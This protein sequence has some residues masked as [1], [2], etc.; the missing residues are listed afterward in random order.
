MSKKVKFP[1][2]L[3]A[4]DLLEGHVLYWQNDGW[5]REY[6]N[7]IIANNEKEGAVLE[8]VAAQETAINKVVDAELVE[9]SLENQTI[10]P[11]HFRVKIKVSG[12]TIEYGL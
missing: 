4:H 10:I 6:I 8:K 12:P 11:T 7:S 3:M 5:S 9:I 1:A 2:I